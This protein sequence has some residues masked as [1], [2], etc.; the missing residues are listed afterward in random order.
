MEWGV[1]GGVRCKK[2]EHMSEMY[3]KYAMD[4]DRS[5]ETQKHLS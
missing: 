3:G 2:G 4:H 1:L 5:D